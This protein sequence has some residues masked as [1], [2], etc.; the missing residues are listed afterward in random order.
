MSTLQD[1]E[2]LQAIVVLAAADGHLSRSEW[3]VIEG[4][5]QRAGVGTVSLQAMVARALE[6]PQVRA[7]LFQTVQKD[8]EHCLKLL[9][10]TARIDGAISAP[11]RGLL[12]DL[13]GMLGV[14][15][16]RF[17]CIYK[18]GIGAADALRTR[19]GAGG[20]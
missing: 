14:T 20:A 12:V 10:A 5:A 19:R 11:E 7:D 16:E 8:R 1:R 15:G 9:V 2:L 18:E 17:E 6:D 3:G 4:L 13:A